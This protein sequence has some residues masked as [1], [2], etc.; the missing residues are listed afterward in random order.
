MN[1]YLFCLVEK[2][3]KRGMGYNRDSVVFV[4]VSQQLQKSSFVVLAVEIK[5]VVAVMLINKPIGFLFKEFK[6]GGRLFLGFHFDFE[7]II[8]FGLI[9]IQ[10]F[11]K[12]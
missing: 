5:S 4:W 8:K 3:E 11:L 1:G 7:K 6:K 10:S 9:E 2:N 12:S